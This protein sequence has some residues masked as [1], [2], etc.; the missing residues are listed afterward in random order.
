[1]PNEKLEK[2]KH[3]Q[4]VGKRST[5]RTMPKKTRQTWRGGIFNDLKAGN[6]MS[7]NTINLQGFYPKELQI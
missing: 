4:Y 5:M 2:L 6:K 1:M 7:K 3:D